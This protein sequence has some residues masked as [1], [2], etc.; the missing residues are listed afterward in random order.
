MRSEKIT[1]ELP[2]RPAIERG[3]KVKEEK[4]NN[5]KRTFCPDQFRE[6]IVNMMEEHLC[7]HPLIPGYSHPSCAGIREWAVKQIYQF[8]AK[9]DLREVWAY[10]WEN[11]YR[12]GQWELWARLCYHEIPV[13]KTTMILESQ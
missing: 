10:L 6:A 13:L 7:A 3:D 2:P 1:I 9:N 11:W 4:F 12:A 5:E 8:C